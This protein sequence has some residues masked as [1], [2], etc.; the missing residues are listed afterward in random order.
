[1]IYKYELLESNGIKYISGYYLSSEK[2]SPRADDEFD[3]P[4]PLDLMDENGKLQWA[5]VP[6]PGYG[7]KLPVHMEEETIFEV[8]DRKWL[9]KKRPQRLSADEIAG[10]ERQSQREKIV[11]LYDHDKELKILREELAALRAGQPQTAAFAEMDARI[12]EITNG[13]RTATETERG[14]L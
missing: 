6:N 11:Q 7:K 13:D 3:R 10:K 14:A 1:M 4:A 5:L 2:G 9:I 12:R 8:D